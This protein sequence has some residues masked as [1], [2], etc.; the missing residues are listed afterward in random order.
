MDR[1]RHPLSH[2]AGQKRRELDC[3]I[4]TCEATFR[5]GLPVQFTGELSTTRRIRK[6]NT[7]R[8]GRQD[9]TTK[10]E[11]TVRRAEILCTIVAALMSVSGLV[12]A[13]DVADVT[14]EWTSEG[15]KLAAERA[16]LPAHDEMVRIPA[17]SFIM[18]SD[19]KVDH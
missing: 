2:E 15:K 3:G 12:F 8:A 19:K 13:L 9:V 7:V 16:K 1:D 10:E 17:G 4:S 18:G 5:L 11:C 6:A 14:R